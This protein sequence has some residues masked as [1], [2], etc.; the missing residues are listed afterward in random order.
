MRN[1]GGICDLDP[2]S[3]L[4]NSRSAIPQPTPHTGKRRK[5]RS[6][7]GRADRLDPGNVHRVAVDPAPRDLL[8]FGRRDDDQ[9]PA[10]QH[11]LRMPDFVGAPIRDMYSQP[12]ERPRPLNLQYLLG[13]HAKPT[14]TP[15]LPST[16]AP[17]LCCRRDA[18]T[19]QDRKPSRSRSAAPRPLFMLAF[20]CRSGN[21]VRCESVAN[22]GQRP[23]RRQHQIDRSLAERNNLGV[24]SVGLAQQRQVIMSR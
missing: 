17:P 13:Y 6:L 2:C 24:I 14:Q 8:T 12:S 11:H 15:G 23:S 4:C 5:S 9:G 7:Q 16:A 1:P 19:S 21:T 18:A 3:T 22:F 10:H 20:R